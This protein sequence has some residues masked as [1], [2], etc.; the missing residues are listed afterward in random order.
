MSTT[1]SFD[2]DPATA[3]SP[4]HDERLT[5]PAMWWVVSLFLAMTFVVA[6]WAI[7]SDAWALGA[8]VVF[9]GLVVGFLLVYGSARITTDDTGVRAGGATLEWEWVAGAT[10][11]DAEQSRQALS[12]AADGRTWLLVRPFLTNSVRV[13]LVDPADPHRHW[14]LASRHP[15]ALAAAINAGSVAHL[16]RRDGVHD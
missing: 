8:L 12:A 15:R 1:S 6:V 9:T 3:P 14:L 2:V 11:L 7:L 16:P 4:S 5:V 10:A 13:D